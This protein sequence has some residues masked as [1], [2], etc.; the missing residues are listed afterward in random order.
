LSLYSHGRPYGTE[1]LRLVEEFGLR[2]AF[3]LENAHLH[4]HAREAAR[5]KDEF[6]R[7]AAHELKTPV[8]SL[9]LAAESLARLGSATPIEKV[10]RT[11]ERIV[12]QVKRLQR[13]VDQ[14]LDYSFA[15]SRRL[16][17]SI[18]Q[19]DLAEV[20]RKTVGA[21]KPRFEQGGCNLTLRVDSPV[22][23]DWDR[24]RLE[25]MLSSLLDNALKFGAGKPVEMSVTTDGPTATVT[26]RD[27]GSGIPPER[28]GSVFDAFERAASPNHYGGLGLGLF[29][30]RAIA[31]VHGGELTAHNLPE[32]GVEF[33]ALLPTHAPRPDNAGLPGGAGP[34]LDSDAGLQP[35]SPRT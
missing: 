24:A 16:S 14:M 27:Y 30:A 31:E 32:G 33:K 1:D 3:A 17:L 28:L 35:S 7:L 21:C 15:A 18:A 34:L 11:S 29:V 19:T 8:T 20:A 6:I 2:L 5:S 25:E 23:G 22:V 9:L 4:Q 12:A 13:L 26:V 10:A